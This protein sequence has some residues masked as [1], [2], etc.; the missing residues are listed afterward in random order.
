MEIKQE[1]GTDSYVSALKLKRKTQAE[2]LNNYNWRRWLEECP[3]LERDSNTGTVGRCKYCGIRINVEF[4]YLRTRHQ[5][6]GK[7]KESEKTHNGDVTHKKSAHEETEDMQQN[8][9]RYVW[10]RNSLS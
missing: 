6:T 4:S 7:H 10:L 1:F 5:E 2:A 9:K 8:S 3:W